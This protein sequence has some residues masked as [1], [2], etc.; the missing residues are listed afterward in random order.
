MALMVLAFS[1]LPC[2]DEGTV[3]EGKAK[4]ELAQ[5][6]PQDNDGDHNDACSPFCICSCCA[7]FSVLTKLPAAVAL[8]ISFQPAHATYIA[9]RL[10][11]IALPIWQPPRLV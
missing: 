7:G 3:T 1:M 9:D 11:S 2:A 5:S 10:F 6:I 4:S 8:P